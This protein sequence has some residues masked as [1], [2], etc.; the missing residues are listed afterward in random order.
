[1]SKRSF[2][3]FSAG[4]TSS[5]SQALQHA[6]EL[7]R[8]AQALKQDLENLR[9]DAEPSSKISTILQGH[10]EKILPATRALMQDETKPQ[11]GNGSHK[12]QKLSDSHQTGPASA[13]SV[14][15]LEFL[16]R[17]TMENISSSGLPQL[18]PVLNS[19]LEQAAFTH[20]GMALKP[21]D[22]SYERLEWLGDAYLY[23]MSSAY[24]YQ[25]FPYLPAGRCAQLR[26][27]LI[28]N[29]TLSEYTIR[30]GM[31][32]RIRFPPDFDVTGKTVGNSVTQKSKKKVLGDVFEAYVAAAILGDSTGLSRVAAWLKSL[33][34]TNLRN[35][36]RKEYIDRPAIAQA[37]VTPDSNGTNPT[38][39]QQNLNPKIILTQ[40]IGTKGVKISY[41]DIGEPKKEKNSGLPWYT[42]GVVYDGLGETNLQL[43]YGSGLS[44][45]EAGAN[46]AR[47]AM[48]NK[49]LI[50]R[51]QK[52]KEDV[53]AAEAAANLDY[54]N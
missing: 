1:M 8:A 7:L 53:R 23:L 19:A 51:L 50:K 32:K 31:D 28:K 6:D 43:G 26:E 10:K 48:E 34:S 16:T 24:I 35:E 33:W 29:E 44:K 27:R 41:H 11:K 37:H 17:W 14:P 46:A 4:N 39:N 25:T 15:N 36:I 22:M 12:S 52:K 5:L 3:E 30:Y 21:T 40:T 54:D 2:E 13:I 38:P 42:V 9:G 47:K 45:K 49:K 18:E 20:S